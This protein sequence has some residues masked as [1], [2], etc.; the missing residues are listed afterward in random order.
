MED[1][2]TRVCEPARCVCRRS[3][4][5][6]SYYDEYH[7]EIQ[8]HLVSSDQKGFY[9]HLVGF[10]AIKQ[11]EE[12]AAHQAVRTRRHTVEGEGTNS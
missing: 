12:R 9:K 2:E 4:C 8:K 10:D 3:T 6:F 1:T 5:V 7:A 11:I